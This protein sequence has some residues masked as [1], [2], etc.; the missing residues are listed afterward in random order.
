[1]G[2]VVKKPG[3]IT[4]IQDVGRFGYQGSG[5]STNGVMDH[6]AFAIAN[7]LVENDPGAPVLEFALA[8]PTVRFTTNTCFAITGGDFAPTLDGEPVPMYAA[9]MVRRGSILRFKASRTGCY[10]YLAIAGNSVRVPEV[11]GSRSTNLKCEF[12]GWKGRTLIVGDY[13]PF[14]TKSV[15]FLPN[16]GSHRIDGDNEF[17]GF[18]RDEI[19]VR[20]VPGP[21][22]DM[23][24]D[25]GLAT[26]YGQ[27][28][29]TTTKCDR[30]GYRLDGPEIETKHGSDIISDGVAFGAVQVPSH[31]RPIIMR[32]ANYRRLRENRHHRQRG[33][34]EA[35][36]T[37]AGRQD[38]LRV[39][40]RAG[41]PSAA[42]RR[43]APVRN[44]GV[45]SEAAQRRRHIAPA[46]GA[47]PDP[48]PGGTGTQV[49]GRHVV[50]RPSRSLP[51]RRQPQRPGNRPAKETTARRNRHHR[52]RNDV[53]EEEVGRGSPKP[54]VT[55][56]RHKRRRTAM[57]TKA[58]EELIAIMDKAELTALRVD[59]G[60]TKI[61]LERNH[62]P[63]SS[64]ALPLM[65]DRVSALLAGKT[66]SHEAA[67]VEDA[68][69]SSILVRSPMVG[70][71]YI[72]PSP[73]EDPF[74]KVGQEVLSGQ[75]LAIVEAMKMM[76]EI[77]TPA[78]GIVVEVL[79]AN[80]T[81]VEY[82]QPL[83]RVATAAGET[84]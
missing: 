71:F 12:G 65:A 32:P 39:H 33:H 80:G 62:G 13:L 64:T 66:E 48:H 55:E 59:D 30:M 43:G 75:T 70:M 5:F 44:A 6:R 77:T 8:G 1:M 37:S 9:V 19:T 21:Q 42:A 57:D 34:P 27:A 79:A 4:T 63:L 29:T 61:E 31:G 78:P 74:V 10:G 72:S 47:A 20:V 56:P 82:D 58:I 41:G 46:H 18:D 14:S 73:D 51:A 11:M 23:F 52:T 40:R 15:D 84:H 17:Y 36:A 2:L 35:G 26:F 50:D 7:L 25:K 69:E 81:Q 68:D 16:L 67:A 3:V 53:D 49:A 24:T 22:Q 28:Y 76:N 83:F 45:E 38:P 54:A 60:E